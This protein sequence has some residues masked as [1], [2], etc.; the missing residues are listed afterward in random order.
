MGNMTVFLI[1]LT[2]IIWLLYIVIVAMHP[3]P[4]VESSFELKRRA[5]HSSAATS[6]L[7]REKRLASILFILRLK[8]ALLLLVGVLLL[9][10]L[11][12]PV[13]GAALAILVVTA[14]HVIASQPP[15]LSL[16]N[17]LYEIIEPP[18]LKLTGKK[19][20]IW[21]AITRDTSHSTDRYRRVDSRED[22]MQLIEKSA[23]GLQEDDRRVITGALNFR[24]QTAAS[25]MVP[26]SEIKS[27]DR[28]E[29]LGPLVLDE[30]HG[31]GHKQLP[32]TSGDIHHVVGVL[33][34]GDLLSLDVKRSVTAEK[35]M[36]KAV[37]RVNRRDALEDVLHELV[38]T[39]QHLAI[40]VND[41]KQTVGLLTL[42]DVLTAL[43][44]SG[45][46]APEVVKYPQDGTNIT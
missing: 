33:S 41:N 11:F 29:F 38:S 6:Q 10:S 19:P 45:R 16:S 5:K 25:V 21:R 40:V 28:K 1:G 37:V 3:L 31:Y 24:Q 23:G 7:K 20:K 42:R 30:L 35:A 26:R 8:A 46:F 27:V 36:S 14:S 43:I 9:V 32:V 44:G 13:A 18:L 2:I 17:R 4:A 39:R 12:H 15:L 22:L 34:L